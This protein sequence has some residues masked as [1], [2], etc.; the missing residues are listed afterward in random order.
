MF[1]ASGILALLPSVAHSVKNSPVVY[2]LLMGF[3]GLGAVLGALLLRPVRTR[4]ATEPVVSAAI[5]IFG[6]TTILAGS[7]HALA[8]LSTALLMGGAAWIVFV[9]RFNVLILNLTADWVRARVLAVFLLV[10]QGAVAA[11]SA[12]WGALAGRIGIHNALLW[13][14]VGTIAAAVAG[15][16]LPLP[17]LSI[18]VTPWIHWP[19]PRIVNGAVATAA[20]DAGP[21]LLTVAYDVTLGKTPEFLDVLHKY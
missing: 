12:T 7:W 19:M 16:F 14:G 15:V 11:G 21:I 18:D 6:L 3:F 20:A 10:F 17:K 2:G 1:Y 8:A 9:S 4:L 13:A 5:V